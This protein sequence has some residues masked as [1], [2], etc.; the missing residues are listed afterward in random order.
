VSEKA[1]QLS[2]D[3]RGLIIVSENELID[4]Q[5][6]DTYGGDYALSGLASQGKVQTQQHIIQ[7]FKMYCLDHGC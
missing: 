3:S 2:N 6:A 1:A 5:A 4:I 7:Y